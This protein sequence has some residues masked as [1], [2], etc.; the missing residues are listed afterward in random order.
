MSDDN[1]YVSP[2]ADCNMPVEDSGPFQLAN[3]GTRLGAYLLDSL[4]VTAV[5]VPWGFFVLETG[6]LL[7][8]ATPV[9]TISVWFVLAASWPVVYFAINGYLLARRGQTLGKRACGIRIVKPDGSVP[10]LWDSFVKRLVLFAVARHL[11]IV[12]SLVPLVDALFIFGADR[13]CLHD[14]VAGT[15]VAKIAQGEGVAESV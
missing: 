6:P 12:G 5:T 10:T 3:R 7:F 8:G 4:I 15:Y 14:Y 2:E 11:P 9:P 1:P 13:R